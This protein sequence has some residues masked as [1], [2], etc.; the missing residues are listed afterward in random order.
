MIGTIKE[1]KGVD[2][3]WLKDSPKSWKIRRVKDI[4][5]KISS[6]VTPKG[7]SETYIDNGIPLIRSQNVYNDGLK[8]QN[9][10]FISNEVHSKMANSKVQPFDVLINITGASIGRACVVPDTI[11]EA[12]INQHI[13]CLRTKREKVEYL[14]YY[15]QSNSVQE[16]I[17]SIQAGS[18][19]EALNMAQTLNIPLLQPNIAVQK[20]ITSYLDSNT[21]SIDKKITLL[22]EKIAIYKEFRKTLINN[23]ILKG[24][25]NDTSHWYSAR[26]KDIGSLYSGLSG[27]SGNDFNQ[28]ENPNNKGFIPFTNIANNTYLD[29][30]HLG[31]VIIEKNENQNR[32]KKGDI[33][34][35]MSS[36][37]YEDIGKSAVLLDDI[38][39][40]YLNSF[41]KG[42][43]LKNKDCE[44]SFINYVLSSDFYRQKMIV[45]GKG[46]TRINL[47]MEKVNNFEIHIPPTKEEQAEIAKFLNLKTD[48][49]DKIVGNIKKQIKTLKE[50]RKTLINDVVTGKIK[51]T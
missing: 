24:L 6:G 5:L 1:S 34:F 37:G 46:F 16:Y 9:V 25:N 30:N 31:T 35:L 2:V 14:A 3:D 48:T 22:Q 4:V 13:I 28:D 7:G 26:L 36:E 38:D 18:S 10:S 8:L 51:V 33:F 44:P 12:N 43:R 15:L 45:E 40:A 41:C 42:F 32:V 21:Q 20:E 50:L 17:M 19:K 23:T 29:K 47:K 11:Q 49:I 39:E 27:K